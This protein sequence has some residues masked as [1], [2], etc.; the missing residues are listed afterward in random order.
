MAAT[1]LALSQ[2]SAGI[3]EVARPMPFHTVA[4]TGCPYKMQRFVAHPESE[5]AASG[6]T[7]P[8]RVRRMFLETVY[9]DDLEYRQSEAGRAPE[10]SATTH[11]GMG[12]NT[13]VTRSEHPTPTWSREQA[14]INALWDT[15][16]AASIPVYLFPPELHMDGDG[17]LAKFPQQWVDC[18][19]GRLNL[20]EVSDGFARGAYKG[21][22][23]PPYLEGYLKET[24]WNSTCIGAS[25]GV[26]DSSRRVGYSEAYTSLSP[27]RATLQ[28]LP[29]R[30]SATKRQSCQERPV[31]LGRPSWSHSWFARFRLKS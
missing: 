27:G 7:P 16:G 4:L 17:W 5:H 3:G 8:P 24:Q 29:V 10:E 31:A 21:T 30:V 1:L 6:T 25:R 20:W 19:E 15:Q 18:I 11:H 14:M 22:T 26:S 2:S 9:S 23:L 12:D 28:S 13:A